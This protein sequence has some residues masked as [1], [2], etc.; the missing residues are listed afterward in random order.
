MSDATT[1]SRPAI[2]GIEALTKAAGPVGPEPHTNGFHHGPAP[3]PWKV[4]AIIPCFNRRADLQ[5]LLRD[6]ARQDLRPIDG[7]PIQ[8]WCVIVDNASAEPL[9]TM[10]VPEGVDRKRHV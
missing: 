1:L 6:V 3:R 9:A 2:V 7:R 5:V 8:L 10:Q 4:A